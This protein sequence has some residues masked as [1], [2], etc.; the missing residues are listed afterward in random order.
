MSEKKLIVVLVSALGGQGGGVLSDW[1][2]T[3]ARLEGFPAQ[4]TSIPGVA[5]RTGATTYLFEVWP[6]K[7]QKTRPV[8]SIYPATGAV[9]LQVSFEPT[10]ASRA[11][12]NGYIGAGTTL[13]TASQ[14]IYSIAEKM[15]PGDGTIALTPVL[16]A[17]EVCSRQLK[18]ADVA[19]AAQKTGCHPN[20][21]MFGV[22]AVSGVLPFNIENCR[23]A[24]A[25][26]GV[27]V[28]ANLAGFDVG[29]SLQALSVEEVEKPEKEYKQPP[30]RFQKEITALPEPVQAMAGHAVSHLCDYQDEN[31]AGRYLSFMN[32]IVAKDSG[33]QNFILSVAVARRLAAWMAFEDVIRVAQLKTRPGRFARIRNELSVGEDVPL[34]VYDYLKPGRAELLGLLPTALA[35]KFSATSAGG[36]ALKIRTSNP[37]GFGLMKLLALL[38]PWRPRTSRFAR[39]QAMIVRWLDTIKQA[40]ETDYELACKVADLAVWARGYGATRE[41]GFEELEAAFNAPPATIVASLAKARA[42]PETN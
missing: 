24:V 6:Y 29:T 16:K 39:E 23:K 14:R 26:S 25:S 5:Q 17:L 40:A 10:E 19:R 9:D 38:K 37:V 11:L 27:A 34:V 7:D 13:I 32:Q 42:I 20:A 30:A 2:T 33:R 8:F 36:I 22:M 21:I 12:M 28:T 1:L 18:I 35:K 3:A 41:R 31:Y 4:A 15:F